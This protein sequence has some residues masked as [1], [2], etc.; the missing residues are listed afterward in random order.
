MKCPMCGAWTR[1]LQSRLPYRVRECGNLHQFTTA[2]SLVFDNKEKKQQQENRRREI[3]NAEGSFQSV[4][5]KYNV[6][7]QTVVNCRKKY[8]TID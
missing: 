6:C 3:A 8:R 2:E 1:V 4:A 5:E 7:V